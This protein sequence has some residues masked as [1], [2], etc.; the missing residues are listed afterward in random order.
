MPTYTRLQVI[1]KTVERCNI[2]CSY[3]YVFNM[4][5]DS[6]RKHPIY[7]TEQTIDE[8]ICFLQEGSTTL[9]L[10]HI[11]FFFLGGEPLMQKKRHFVDMCSRLK[12]ELTPLVNIC[13]TL[14]TNGML[15][16]KEWIDIFNRFR[17]SVGISLDGN[18]IQNDRYRVD[19]FNRGTYD[20]VVAKLELMQQNYQGEVSLLCVINPDN[21]AK[22]L[23]NHFTKVLGV[24]WFDFLLPDY[25]FDNK[26]ADFDPLAYGQFLC[27]LFDVWVNDIGSG[28]YVRWI[29]SLFSVLFLKQ[30]LMHGEG[31]AKENE[32]PLISISSNGELAPLDQLRNTD[33]SLVLDSQVTVKNID[34]KSFLNKEIFKMLKHAQQKLPDAC[35]MCCWQSICNGGALMNRYSH[36]KKFDNPSLYCEGLKIFYAHVA[37][38]LLGNGYE[39]QKL[40]R[41]LEV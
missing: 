16:D 7:I 40:V 19:H 1:I 15:I 8:I 34:L 22:E 23:Y 20:R 32:L 21:S 26:P 17:V 41:Q 2:N 13:F 9:G 38:F 18:K 36:S 11:E 31:P 12:K 30:G 28:I 35:Q 10:E 5:D 24:K 6:Y 14:Q 33:P 4:Q 29:E 39:E 3:C 25:H 37:A 27:D